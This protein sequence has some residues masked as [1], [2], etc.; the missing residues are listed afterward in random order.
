MNAQLRVV[1]VVESLDR[2][3]LERVVCDLVV[4][5][6]R[7]G[8]FIEVFCI[9]NRGAFAAELDDAGIGVIAAGKT[10][11]PSLSVLAALRAVV[12]RSGHQIV[13]T[14]NPVANYYA[15]AAELTSWRTR[16][17]INTRH[18]M[19][20]SDP[21]DRRE[22]LFR[23]SV[24]RNARVAMVSPQVSLRF[25]ADRIVPAAKATV[26]MNG[27]PVRRYVRAEVATRAAAR[28]LLGLDA[29]AFVVGT[30]G[31]LVPVKNHALLLQ[32]AAPI[33]RAHADARVVL[34]GSGELRSELRALADSLGIAGSLCLPGERA[35]IARLLPAFDVFAMP[36]RSE[37][38]SIA[39][40]E[41]AATGL[42]I[43][44]TSVGGNPEIIEDGV[45]G[46][47]VPTDDAGALTR[48]LQSL[49][50]DEPRRQALGTRAREWSLREVSVETMA[51]K[52]ERIYRDELARRGGG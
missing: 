24:A 49:M 13:H 4:E 15:C 19:G 41:A 27:I 25:I 20:A 22:K 30:V 44:A 7:Q 48:A 39:L 8:H 40:L 33:C 3:G 17:V 26:V 29:G 36:S 50:A 28:A 9:F 2:G 42:A 51:A 45:T 34:I 43:I 38:H 21:H 11:G 10:R 14:H 23:L 32:A 16:P 1:H 6:V 5:Q 31:R 37:G 18:N 47:L 46:L 52:Y 12:R 35:D